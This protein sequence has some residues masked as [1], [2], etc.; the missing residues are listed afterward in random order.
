M[1][2]PVWGTLLWRAPE[3]LYE[4]TKMSFCFT[5]RTALYIKLL[6]KCEVTAQSGSAALAQASL[7]LV[8]VRAHEVHRPRRARPLG[9]RGGDPPAHKVKLTG[10]TQNS[11]VELTQ[12]F[13]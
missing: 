11:Q 12:Q 13:D 4:G 9:V 6:R 7:R 8:E 10:L 3:R 2:W 1:V 5:P